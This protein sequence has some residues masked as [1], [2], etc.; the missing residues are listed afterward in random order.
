M[1]LL[2]IFSMVANVRLRLVFKATY[3]M[4]RERQMND[5]LKTKDELIEE[6]DFLHKRIAEDISERKLTEKKLQ[7]SNSLLSST[8]NNPD[9]L[10][11]FALDKCY[12][13]LSFNESHAREI[14]SIY[15]TDIEI[16]QHVFSYITNQDD[17]LKAKNNYERVLKGER[18]VIREDIGQLN[19]RLCYELI[20]N[21]IVDTSNKI[22]GFTVFCTNITERL[23]FKEEL[24]KTRQLESVGLLAGGI[25][26]D[27]NNILTGLFGNIQLATMKL[28]TDHKAFSYIQKAGQTQEKTSKL[29]QQLLKISKGGLPILETINIHHIIQDSIKFSLSGTSVKTIINLHE[30]LW[31]VIA[32]KRQLSNVITNLVINAEQ[33]M[34]EGGTLYFKAENIMNCN[35]YP[36]PNLSEECVKLTIRDEGVGISPENLEAIFDPNYTTK[37]TCS[38]LGLG[39]ATVHRVISKHN[40]HISVDSKL[41]TGTTFTLYLPTDKSTY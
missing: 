34:P 33:A 32:D 15:N 41:G 24:N 29:S 26:H 27:F 5:Q 11:M 13:Y 9:N 37:Q 21:P 1:L 20:F 38:G 6:L 36:I 8:I 2:D 40:G 12:N 31:Q 28:P 7:E 18:F 17:I 14:K 39:L 30:N 25:V 4:R 35:E 10:I 23:L 22:T 3:I 19:N 16:G